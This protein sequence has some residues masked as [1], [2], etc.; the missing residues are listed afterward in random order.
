MQVVAVVKTDT[1][2]GVVLA[3]G[4]SRRMGVD[5][6]SLMVGGK[7]MIAHVIDR[8][9]QVLP[10]VVVV[11]KDV[12]RLNLDMSDVKV[13]TDVSDKEGALVGIYS[14]LRAVHTPYA[15]VIACDMPYIQ[16]DLVR[17]MIGACHGYDAFVPRVGTEIEPL[18]ALYSRNCLDSIEKRLDAGDL[19]VRGFFEDVNT[20]YAAESELRAVDPDLASFININTAEDLEKVRRCLDGLDMKESLPIRSVVDPEPE[21]YQVVKIKRFRNAGMEE[22]AV[23]ELDDSVIAETEASIYLNGKFVRSIECSPHHVHVLAVGHL[24]TSGLISLGQK[25]EVNALD[26]LSVKV[27]VQQQAKDGPTS[28]DLHSRLYV[29]AGCISD[30]MEDLL[31]KSPLFG[32]TGAAHAAALCSSNGIFCWDE[33]ISRHN[34]VDKVI[35]QCLMMKENLTDKFLL[36]TG[37]I[38]AEMVKKAAVCGVQLVVSKAPPTDKGIELARESGITIVGFVRNRRFNVYCHPQRVLSP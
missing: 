8:V 15:F 38:N 26:N 6:A 37:R 20:V 35:G 31:K 19:R 11:T 25:I 29:T 32:V 33:D 4:Q 28:Q 7:Q 9:R 1:V 13:V 24:F 23:S 2:T 14:A 36:I 3:G 16:P 21:S 18:F 12:C 22:E 27:L 34:A 10:N 5:K 17:W 30:A